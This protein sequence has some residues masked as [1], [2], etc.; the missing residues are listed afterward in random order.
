M[1][2][3]GL[4][5]TSGVRLASNT[6]LIFDGG[7]RLATNRRLVFGG[8]VIV[9]ELTV[10]SLSITSVGQIKSVPRLGISL[11]SEPGVL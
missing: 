3:L 5:I 7:V 8:L 10:M 2:R 6:R 9:I 1:I 11:V 4:M